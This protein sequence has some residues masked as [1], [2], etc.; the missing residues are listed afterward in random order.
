MHGGGRV[1]NP[2]IVGTDLNHTQTGSD[3]EAAGFQPTQLKLQLRGCLQPV[4]HSSTPPRNQPARKT[5]PLSWSLALVLCFNNKSSGM[6]QPQS[7][8]WFT[9]IV[10]A[11]IALLNMSLPFRSMP[12]HAKEPDESPAC[13]RQQPRCFFRCRL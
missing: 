2:L 6:H 4:V 9:M 11:I 10:L 13:L 8:A 3:A 12:H 1:S 5:M 7:R